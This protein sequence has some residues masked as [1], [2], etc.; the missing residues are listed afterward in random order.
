MY[1]HLLLP[2]PFLQWRASMTDE[3]WIDWN[4]AND[5]DWYNAVERDFGLNARQL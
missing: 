3:E 4:A 1:F 5:D 2:V